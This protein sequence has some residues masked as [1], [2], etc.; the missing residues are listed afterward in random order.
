[1]RDYHAHGAVASES[2]IYFLIKENN[3]W[4]RDLLAQCFGVPE[5]EREALLA[6]EAVWKIPNGNTI[7]IGLMDSPQ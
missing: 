7:T 6:G 3:K 5:R 1:M 4:A 2:L